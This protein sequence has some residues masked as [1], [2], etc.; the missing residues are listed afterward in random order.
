MECQNF[1]RLCT[2]APHRVAEREDI[3][4][5][6]DCHNNADPQGKDTLFIDSDSQ[7]SI[8]INGLTLAAG[9]KLAESD[10]VWWDATEKFRIARVSESQLLITPTVGGDS[11][12]VKT[13]GVGCNDFLSS[14]GV[15]A[16]LNA[17]RAA[18]NDGAWSVCA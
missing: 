8:V 9:K 18:C 6:M 5:A 1:A 2:G 17:R 15:S 14:K 4:L 16:A 7:G 12:M 13:L 11:I 3:V 10:T